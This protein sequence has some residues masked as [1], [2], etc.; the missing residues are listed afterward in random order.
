MKQFI[1]SLINIFLVINT[2]FIFNLFAD[3]KD[4]DDLTGKA[5]YCGDQTFIKF[6]M[7]NHESLD[8]TIMRKKY[9]FKELKDYKLDKRKKLV[10]LYDSKWNKENFARYQTDLTSILILDFKYYN[11]IFVHIN[12]L[13]DRNSNFFIAEINR[14]DLSLINSSEIYKQ[15]EIIDKPDIFLKNLRKVHIEKEEKEE[16]LK[17]IEER[18]LKKGQKI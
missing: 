5:L 13:I 8:N 10:Y 1:K 6:I 18:E 14:Q 12:K 16:K 2:F 17:L 15:C 11:G 9:W 7:Y 3:H 4:S